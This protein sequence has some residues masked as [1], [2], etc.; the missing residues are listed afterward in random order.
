MGAPRAESPHSALAGAVLRY[1]VLE[2]EAGPL[3]HRIVPDG[4][5]DLLFNLGDGRGIR[6]G[7]VEP[8]ACAVGVV[9]GPVVVSRPERSPALGVV[10]SPAAARSF[11]DVPVESL[12]DRVVDLR[13]LWGR[14]AE[15]LLQGLRGARDFA[16]SVRYLDAFLV[17][18]LSRS[19]PPD[20]VV[21]SALRLIKARRGAIPIHELHRE[22]SVPERRLERLFRQCTG[23]SPKR[24]CRVAQ[25]DAARMR[26]VR[27]PVPDWPALASELGFADQAHMIREFRKLTGQTPARYRR[28]NPVLGEAAP[29]LEGLGDDGALAS[30][31]LADVEEARARA[32]SR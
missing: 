19:H 6:D 30:W 22:L 10:L 20:P 9:T 26:L 23:L 1:F 29:E 5:V 18:K 25:I 16:A 28:E 31:A 2:G 4:C 24:M 27:A 11:L 12:N 3:T 14:E 7:N 17:A 32:A 13:E 21:L 8:E 15:P